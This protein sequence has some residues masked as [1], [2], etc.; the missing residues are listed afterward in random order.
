MYQ[1]PVSTSYVDTGLWNA[2]NSM[3]A[4]S[5]AVAALP[6]AYRYHF[7]YFPQWHYILENTQVV[8][9]GFE[10]ALDLQVHTLL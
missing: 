6:D 5:R 10:T 2:G 4:A 3:I 7:E 8:F 1:S 9:L